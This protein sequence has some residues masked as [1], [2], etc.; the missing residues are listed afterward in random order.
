[1][2]L[3]QTFF[4][5]WSKWIDFTYCW[6]QLV[7]FFS[8]VIKSV[9]LFV[10]LDNIFKWITPHINKLVALF[11]PGSPQVY[12][13]NNGHG[14]YVCLIFNYL[15]VT[16]WKKRKEEK[17]HLLFVSYIYYLSNL[18]NIFVSDCFPRGL[19]FYLLKAS[20]VCCGLLSCWGLQAHHL[21]WGIQGLMEKQMHHKVNRLKQDGIWN[22]H[23]DEIISV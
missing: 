18:N 8:S 14:F 6:I 9:L 16:I 22:H 19:R 17:G 2:A 4:F 13:S 23:E 5:Q 7:G 10:P 12:T 15:L 11:K 20:L 21:Y 1:M 3:S